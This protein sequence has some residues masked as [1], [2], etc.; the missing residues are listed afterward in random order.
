MTNV[1]FIV[2]GR[3]VTGEFSNLSV[4]MISG[5]LKSGDLVGFSILGSPPFE[6]ESISIHGRFVGN[7]SEGLIGII[8]IPYWAE[9]YIMG[10]IVRLT[11]IKSKEGDFY[12]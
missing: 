6:V 5:N 12:E 4:R 7:I 10:P 11:R 2:V 1:S 9:S 8:S 3:E